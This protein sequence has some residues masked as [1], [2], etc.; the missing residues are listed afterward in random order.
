MDNDTVINKNES[1]STLHSPTP[2]PVGFG[3][4]R[5]P[6]LSAL[7]SGKSITDAALEVH[8]PRTSCYDARND[9]SRFAEAWQA[10][11]DSQVESRRDT[12]D[13]SLFNR[14]AHGT[15]RDIYYQGEVCGSETLFDTAAAKAWAQANDPR[16]QRQES[17]GVGP[18]QVT[19]DLSGLQQAQPVDYQ[20]VVDATA[21]PV[22]NPAQLPEAPPLTLPPSSSVFDPR[23]ERAS[24]EEVPPVS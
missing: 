15:E 11:I 22:D 12:M 18:I 6:F 1:L 17:Q 13:S 16:Y 7:A 19:I 4:W 14:G 20:G 3:D 9:S 24:D 23:I 2:R 21:L 8:R 5:D 10:A